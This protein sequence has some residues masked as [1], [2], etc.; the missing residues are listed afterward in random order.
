MYKLIVNWK[1]IDEIIKL[2]NDCRII[3][4]VDFKIKDIDRLVYV[5]YADCLGDIMD[6]ESSEAFYTSNIFNFLFVD[7]YG[8]V[9]KWNLI[10]HEYIHYLQQY[11]YLYPNDCSDDWQED[12]AVK[13]QC[14]VRGIICS[15][16]RRNMIYQFVTDKSQDIEDF[17]SYKRELSVE[18][19]QNVFHDYG[20]SFELVEEPSETFIE[21]YFYDN[22]E[23]HIQR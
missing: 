1:S 13:L 18:N 15:K 5:V 8:D 17:I 4:K 23:S 20:G 6:F 22:L 7:L 21:K 10:A 2:M 12:M 11:L 16:T 19:Y 9:E 3:E 14:K